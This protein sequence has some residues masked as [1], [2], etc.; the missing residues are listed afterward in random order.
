MIA[1]GIPYMI[2][3]NTVRCSRNERAEFLWITWCEDI[4]QV[5]INLRIATYEE[6]IIFNSVFYS[7]FLFYVNL[8]NFYINSGCISWN[9]SATIKFYGINKV[10][11]SYFIVFT[12]RNAILSRIDKN[13]FLYKVILVVKVAIPTLLYTL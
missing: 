10:K 7:V 9:T 3:W 4:Y 2:R 8:S 13:T 6:Y 11:I 1:M 12:L 5:A